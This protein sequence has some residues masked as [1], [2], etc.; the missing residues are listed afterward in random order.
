[1]LKALED[2]G[3]VRVTLG[4]TNLCDPVDYVLQETITLDDMGVSVATRSKKGKAHKS[5]ARKNVQKPRYVFNQG[6]QFKSCYMDYF[7]P[8][9]RTV[10]TRLLGLSEMVRHL[11]ASGPHILSDGMLQI[12]PKYSKPLQPTEDVASD[13]DTQT[14]EETQE[15]IGQV[16]TK[17]TVVPEETAHRPLKKLKMSVAV[18]VDLAE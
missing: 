3:T 8:N 13:F 11:F 7:D 12:K 2:Q 6:I 1:M 9:N 14:Q 4:S 18:G 15:V 5:K 16:S 10:E 17:R